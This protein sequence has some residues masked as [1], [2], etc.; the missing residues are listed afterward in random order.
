MTII[1]VYEIFF[2][3]T[4]HIYA[5]VILF[6]VS[7][8][9]FESL[10]AMLGRDVTFP[11]NSPDSGV[12]WRCTNDKYKNRL[13]YAYGH[14]LSNF[15]EFSIHIARG[16]C[17]LTMKITSS[18]ITQCD[19]FTAGGGELVKKYRTTIVAGNFFTLKFNILTSCC[20]CCL[21]AYITM[22]FVWW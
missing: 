21:L 8:V 2:W 12:E 4:Y 5:D 1:Y 19:C 13:I 14:S 9:E 17:N 3:E 15:S 10:P 16:W 20:L 18:D 7:A 6:V 11:C 22:L